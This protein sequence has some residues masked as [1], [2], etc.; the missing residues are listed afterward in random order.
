MDKGGG[1]SDQTAVAVDGGCLDR[2]DLMLAE[3]F[4]DQVEPGGERCVAKGPSPFA[5]E[6]R[7]DGG[8]EGLFW[9]C[10]L[11]LGLGKRCRECAD[12][13]AGVMRE[14]DNI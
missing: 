2:C 7:D 6:G 4:A 5:R 3:A 11:G 8:G 9:I 12:A 1:K 14:A 13:I 10:N